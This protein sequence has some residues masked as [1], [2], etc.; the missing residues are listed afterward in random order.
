MFS[1]KKQTWKSSPIQATFQAAFQAILTPI[2]PHLHRKCE[3][4]HI[5]TICL[6]PPGICQNSDI[7]PVKSGHFGTINQQITYFPTNQETIPTILSTI[8]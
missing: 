4:G 2:H 5:L 1:K 3:K 7:L 6:L 8:I